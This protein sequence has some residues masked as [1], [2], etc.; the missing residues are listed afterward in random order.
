MASGATR[1]EIRFFEENGYLAIP[2]FV[3]PDLLAR[4]EARCA[5]ELTRAAAVTADDPLIVYE[6]TPDGAPRVIR[7]LSR[8]ADRD[9]AFMRVACHPTAREYLRAL[10]GNEV[11]LCLN[12]H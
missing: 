5:D 2:R 10:L 6:K 1:D 9:D 11:E 12:R 8:M 4:V 3:E 7:R